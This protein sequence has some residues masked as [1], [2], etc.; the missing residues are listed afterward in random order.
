MFRVFTP[1]AKFI[2]SVFLTGLFFTGPAAAVEVYFFKG[3]GD[4]SF[5]N[6]DLH[7]SRGL[8][9]MADALNKEGIHAE[10]R[11]FGATADAL[12][13]IRARKPQ[14][15]AFIGHSMG[16]LASMTMAKRMK[17][18]GIRVAYVGTIDIP[19]PIGTAGKNVEWA[20]NYFSVFPVYGKLTNAKTHP[21]AKNIYVFGQIHTTMDDSK[22]VRQGVL[23]AIREIDG[24]ERDAL[25]VS[26]EP[27]MVESNVLA[28]QPVIVAQTKPRRRLLKIDENLD[29]GWDKKALADR[30]MVT[31]VALA[32]IK[33]RKRMLKI[34]EVD[35]N[36]NN[37]QG[38]I[39]NNNS[40]FA[41][42]APAHALVETQAPQDPVFA[43]SNDQAP[44]NLLA[45][46]RT[47]AR[48][49]AKV[50]EP[51]ID[52]IRTGSVR[53]VKRNRTIDI[54][55][56]TRRGKRVIG[57]VTAFFKRQRRALKSRFN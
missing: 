44:I 12:R 30:M 15:V 25:G 23:A 19:G 29:E 5:I 11:R 22:K 14:S 17:A 41:S 2:F 24:K 38:V 34:D 52:H 1:L 7:F 3:A 53:K 10:V 51:K 6:K 21:K 56:L 55:N 18:L 47:N 48:P 42:V 40:Q 46:P 39:S 13:T 35:P 54:S 32:P 43:S 50:R 27:L 45:A 4:F 36:A 26:D 49:V 31:R 57:K 9:R 16:A 8:E 28:N 37:G 20:E 33:P